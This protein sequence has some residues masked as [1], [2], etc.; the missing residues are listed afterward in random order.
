M[1][2]AAHG[3]ARRASETDTACIVHL[4]KRA[5]SFDSVKILEL[6]ECGVREPPCLPVPGGPA[7]GPS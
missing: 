7:A 4:R 2:W 1:V 6:P 3:E 5:E